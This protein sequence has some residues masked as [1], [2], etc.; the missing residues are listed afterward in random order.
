MVTLILV[1]FVGWILFTLFRFSS[2]AS[3]TRSTSSPVPVK[4]HASIRNPG[5]VSR[6]H[7][8]GVPHHIGGK[9]AKNF[10][11]FSSGQSLIAERESNNVHDSNAIVLRTLAGKK[12]GYIP[13]ACNG[14]HAS[15]MDTGGKV[16]VEIVSVNAHSPWDGV[17]I[18]VR[19]I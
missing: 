3:A 18:S 7:I 6:C 16:E 11:I 2:N 10:S 15:H 19:N 14:P 5:Y 17:A 4:I 9:A 1:V 12:V 8:A 13:R